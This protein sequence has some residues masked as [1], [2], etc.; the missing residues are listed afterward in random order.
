MFFASNYFYA[1]QGAVNTARFDGPTRA[2]NAALEGAGAIVGALIIGYTV[3]DL[4]WFHRRTRGYLG[5]TTVTVMT[6]IV[7]GVGLSWQ[8]TFTRADATDANRINYHDDNYKGKGA[9]YFFCTSLLLLSFPV[10]YMERHADV[11]ASS[12]TQTTSRTRATRRSHTGSCPHSRTTPSSSPGTQA[13]T[14]PCSPRGPQ[15]RSAWTP[16]RP[17]S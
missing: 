4:K 3:L 14:R 11:V 15:A 5:L 13:C 8:V 17:R 12:C 10:G 2:L 9:L 7:W 1:Y 6:I 16:S